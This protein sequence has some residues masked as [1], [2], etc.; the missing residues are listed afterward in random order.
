MAC[1]ELSFQV[2]DNTQLAP[3]GCRPGHICIRGSS[4]V[5]WEKQVDLP[6]AG[7]IPLPLETVKQ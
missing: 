1:S 6:G 7:D 2:Q 4:K 5:A 3:F